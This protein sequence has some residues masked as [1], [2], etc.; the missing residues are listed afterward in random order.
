[1]TGRLS[2][3]TL[4]FL[5]E[6]FELLFYLPQLF[7]G[8]IFQIDQLISRLLQRANDFVELQMHRFSVAVLGVLNQEHHQKRNDGGS[9]VDDQLPGI[10]KMKCWTG[11]K[12]DQDHEHGSSKGPRAS[13]HAGGAAGKDAKGVAHHA[14]EVS[15][16]FVLF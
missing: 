1:M 9:S 3:V 7:V 16:L 5:S 13:E 14:Q 15:L 8:K 2:S 10:G 6:L 4:G 12:P 11:E